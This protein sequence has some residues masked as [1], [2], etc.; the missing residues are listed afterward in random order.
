MYFEKKEIVGDSD[1]KTIHLPVL[2]EKRHNVQARL[3]GQ[4][5]QYKG[6]SRCFCQRKLTSVTDQKGDFEETTTVCDVQ[7]YAL[8]ERPMMHTE[9]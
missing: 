2:F 1:S 7:R 4:R 8:G 6:Q 5:L 9:R 3:R